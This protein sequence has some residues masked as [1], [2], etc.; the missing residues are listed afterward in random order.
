MPIWKRLMNLR[1]KKSTWMNKCST[2]LK[3]IKIICH[4]NKNKKLNKNFL[5]NKIDMIQFTANR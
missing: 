5:L 4:K 1:L 3:S 2:L